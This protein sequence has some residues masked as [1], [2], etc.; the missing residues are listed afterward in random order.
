MFFLFLEYRK[1][2]LFE[3]RLVCEETMFFSH[4]IDPKIPKASGV[5]SIANG[6][7]STPLVADQTYTMKV[8][9]STDSENNHL[10]LL[11]QAG[12]PSPQ[13]VAMDVNPNG[14]VGLPEGV[15]SSGLTLNCADPIPEG[16]NPLITIKNGDGFTR[17]TIGVQN[18]ETG[19]GNAGSD[20]A[21]WS[22]DDEGTYLAQPL[23]INRSTGQVSVASG[24]PLGA[25]GQQYAGITASSKL[26]PQNGAPTT[27][28]TFNMANFTGKQTFIVNIDN[29]A[30]SSLTTGDSNPVSFTLYLSNTLNGAIN[31]TNA[32]LK[33]TSSSVGNGVPVSMPSLSFV[34]SGS[35]SPTNLYLNAVATASSGYSVQLNNV[36]FNA[37]I[38]AP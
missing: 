31:N 18:D 10:L 13:V 30:I 22:Y 34:Y 1:M 37:S 27:V 25:V 24:A 15:E 36:A 9:S 8:V 14:V 26:L 23:A 4:H 7:T 29:F 33:Y 35:T 2:S 5:L 28:Y 32:C 19:T 11:G 17:W 21:V 3:N 20:L 38:V 12:G 6:H 16:G